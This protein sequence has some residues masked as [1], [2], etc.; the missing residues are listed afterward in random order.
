MIS[1][2][3]DRGG[4]RSPRHMNWSSSPLSGSDDD[5]RAGDPQIVAMLARR[6]ERMRFREDLASRIATSTM[7]LIARSP[8]LKFDSERE[9]YMKW[10]VG[11]AA[12]ATVAAAFVLSIRQNDGVVPNWN[13]ESVATVD[14]GGTVA[15]PVLVSLLAG[16]ETI[17]ADGRLEFVID[18]ASAMPILRTRDA[19]YG[20]LDSEV[21][22][23][24]ASASSQ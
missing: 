4:R 24:L 11:L 21:R 13:N 17:S 15:E 6:G 18:D 12:A 8:S 3:I 19:S 16:S 20:D 22:L 9:R 2:A 23:I 7:P 10:G 1:S 5:D 14:S